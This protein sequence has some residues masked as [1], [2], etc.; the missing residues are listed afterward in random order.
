MNNHVTASRKKE[1]IDGSPGF[2]DLPSSLREELAGRLHEETFAAD[3]VVVKEGDLADRLYLIDFGR[4][5]VRTRGTVGEVTLATLRAG[6]L[7]GEIA[8][9]SD[10]RRRRATVRAMETLRVVSLLVRDF[11]EILKAHPEARIDFAM[12][13]DSRLAERYVKTRGA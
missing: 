5:E 3:V 6:D 9:L 11:E 2:A 7:F 1:L 12:G 4:A 13:A 8:L 10:A